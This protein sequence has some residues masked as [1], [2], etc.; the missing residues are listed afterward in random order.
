MMP[1][2]ITRTDC[3]VSLIPPLRCLWNASG[4]QSGNRPATADERTTHASQPLPH[5]VRVPV[6][7]AVP[8]RLPARQ[9]RFPTT[10]NHM[11]LLD[12]GDRFPARTI[13]LADGKTIELPEALAGGY[14]VVVLYRGS[15]C[16]YCNARLSA[17]QRAQDRL[18]EIDARVVALSVD[19]E[20]TTQGTDRQA[21]SRVPGR[22]Q[23]GR[24]LRGRCRGR[25]CQP[26][27]ASSSVHGLRARSRRPG[28]RQRSFK[29]CDRPARA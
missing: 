1:G 24:R 23:R 9:P 5:A 8:T 27:A 28:P 14:G 10:E 20:A 12:P 13:N 3:R 4:P 11:T 7:P 15:W 29:R 17:F 2:Q 26:R 21:R 18:E 25:L 6:E 16:P 22:P 19:D